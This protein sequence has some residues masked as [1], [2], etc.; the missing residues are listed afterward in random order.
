MRTSPRPICAAILAGLAA[1]AASA[2][3]G[4]PASVFVAP[5]TEQAFSERVEAIGTLAPKERVELSVNVADRVTGV[6]FE[7]GQRVEKGQT[8]L[9]QAQREQLAA[10]EG[11]EA[12]AREA[13]RIVERMR[14]LVE[15]GVVSELEFD[16]AKRNYQ[17]AQSEL[18]SV[19]SRQRDRVLV[20]PFSGVLGFRQ[21]SVGAYLNPGTPVATLI[22]DSEMLLD[23]AIPAS[24]LSSVAPGVEIS[25]TTN[26]FPGET[27]E[28]SLIS[29]NNE[30]DPVTRSLRVRAVLPNPDRRLK[31]GLSMSVTLF[32]SP[33]TGLA[34]PEG[35]IE[36]IGSKSFVYAVERTPEGPVARRREV[37]LGI[38]TRGTVEIVSGLQP[39]DQ[40]VSEGLIRI[41]A[42]AP[43]TI[44]ENLFPSTGEAV[45]VA[46]ETLPDAQAVR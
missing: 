18:A 43:V 9:T 2:Q 1:F 10:I 32:T 40:V 30:I 34:V 11:A 26:A 20:A 42:G 22:D 35:A 25:A 39:G 6:Y 38:R 33:H 28:G 12:T 4:G 27:F 21:V 29:V 3:G 46:A 14:P 44:E 8:L 13:F 17:V 16:E 5:V 37:T 36:P 7:D 41:R 31:P 24:F 23:L 45:S 19:Q 15:D